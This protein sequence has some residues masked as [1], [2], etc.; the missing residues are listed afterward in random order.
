[1][2]LH[3]AHSGTGSRPHADDPKPAAP[4]AAGGSRAAKW[5]VGKPIDQA[6]RPIRIVPAAGEPLVRPGP[7][8]RSSTAATDYRV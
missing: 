4:V 5:A 2:D 8:V 1:M 3:A 7:V 6:L